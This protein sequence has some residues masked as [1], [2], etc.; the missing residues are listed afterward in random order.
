MTRSPI[1]TGP[2]AFLMAALGLN[3]RD[4]AAGWADGVSRWHRRDE[5][6]GVP[7]NPWPLGSIKRAASEAA[8]T[9][10]R[11]KGKGE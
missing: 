2:P 7:Y 3:A 9:F 11:E 1:F 6:S 5:R 4:F 10:M 8:V